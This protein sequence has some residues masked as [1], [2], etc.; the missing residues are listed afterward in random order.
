M[1]YLVF[2]LS[3]SSIRCDSE[4]AVLS[5]LGDVALG[6]CLLKDPSGSSCLSAVELAADVLFPLMGT[7]FECCSTTST[8]HN[9]T[10]SAVKRFNFDRIRSCAT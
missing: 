7:I 9:G 1:L 8:D 4:R 10:R 3:L 5:G 2:S 6:E